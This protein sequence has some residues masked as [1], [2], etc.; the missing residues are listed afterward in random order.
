MSS[1]T[2][3]Q[4]TQGVGDRLRD[5]LRRYGVV[6]ILTFS[7]LVLWWGVRS[8]VS[9]D[10]VG[11]ALYV[12]MIALILAAEFWI[13]FRPRW[14][15]I[16]DVTKND[17]A[18]FLITPLTDALQMAILI[19]VLSETAQYHQYL[20]VVAIW[21]NHWP[22]PAQL[23]VAIL[24]VDFFKYWYHRLTHT[25]PLLWRMHIIHHSIDRLQMLRASYFFPLDV[26]LT[27]AIGTLAMLAIGCNY[28]L[29]VMQNVFTGI[30]GLLN[31][32]NADWKCPILDTFINT[33]DHHRAHH[34]IEDPGAH[35]NYGSFFNFADRMFGSRFLPTE[36]QIG[37]LGLDDSWDVPESVLEQLQVPF[38]WDEVSKQG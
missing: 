1:L 14:G 19:G 23:L 10:I 37:E 26:F 22:I 13:P 33:P 24:V 35:A 25:V 9:L 8:T 3:G 16:R 29:I 7:F 11:N 38:R 31:H 18:Y 27:V 32:S 30:L 6:T 36:E 28:K 15:T 21:P 20:E 12:S 4:S 34:S 2:M 5:L 17:V